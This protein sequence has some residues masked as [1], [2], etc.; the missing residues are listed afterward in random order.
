MKFFKIIFLIIASAS[1]LRSQIKV[2]PTVTHLAS[3]STPSAGAITL[4]VS[5][6]AA[7]Y[8]Y[9]WTP[10]S[11]TTQ[12]ISGKPYGS[13]TVKVTDSGTNTATFNY[14]IGYKVNWTECFATVQKHDT[15]VNDGSTN[16]GWGAAV[17]KN[18]LAGG[19]DGWFE[20]ILKDLNHYKK[21]GFLDSVSL[22]K[23][24]AT[25]I[26]YG[27]YYVVSQNRLCKIVN[28]AESTILNNPA[29]GTV[30]R[31]ERVGNVISLK[32]NGTVTYSTTSATD[33][34][35]IWK[36]KTS[37]NASDNGSFINVGCSFFSQGNI[38]FPGFGG[39]LPRVRHI[40]NPIANNGSITVNPSLNGNYTYSWQPGSV[41][42]SSITSLSLGSYSLTIQDSMGNKRKSVYSVGH[43]IRWGQFYGTAEKHD[44]LVNTGVYGWAHGISKN[45]IPGSTDGW[46][47]YVL[48]DLNQI[49]TIGFLD[50]IYSFGAIADVDYGFY[51][52]TDAKVL[53][54]V[55][56]GV[57]SPIENPLEGSILRVERV[58]STINLKV[59]GAVIYTTVNVTDV[60][61]KW[62]VKSHVLP[63]ATLIG[64]GMSTSACSLTAS[65]G[66][67]Q[68]ITCA[69][70]TVTLTGSSNTSGVTYSWSPGGSSPTSSITSVTSPGIYTLQVT[71]AANGCI[72]TSTTSVIQNICGGAVVA[73]YESDALGGSIDLNITGGKGPYNIAWNGVKLPSSV[74]A[75]NIITSLGYPLS[76]DSVIIK[77]GID[78][79]RQV[80]S[81]SGLGPGKHPVTIYDQLNDSINIIGV[82][83][84]EIDTAFTMGI[85]VIPTPSHTRRS[86]NISYFYGESV[87]IVQSGAFTSGQNFAVFANVI[88]RNENNV[89]EFTI[90]DTLKTEYVGLRDQ[91]P[92]IPNGTDDIKQRIC[93]EFLGS[94]YSV[95]V[96][97][98]KQYAGNYNPG[99]VFEMNIDPVTDFVYFSKNDAGVYKH[100]LSAVS[101]TDNL[102][103]KFVHGSA[104]GGIKD[105]SIKI[106]DAIKLRDYAINAIIGD[107]TCDL[108]CSGS[109][110]ATGQMFMYK[111]MPVQYELYSGA[112]SIPIA[113]VTD[114]SGGDHALFTNLCAG[115]Y[116]VK[117]CVTANVYYH[118]G[119]PPVSLTKPYCGSETFEIGYRPEWVNK[120]NVTSSFPGT[121]T[122]TSGNT[123]N[124]DAG[125]SSANYLA[126][127]SSG[128]I[129]WTTPSALSI[130]G[131]G[132][133]DADQ[134]QDIANIDY[135]VGYI[136]LAAPILGSNQLHFR[137]NNST[138]INAFLSGSP[139]GTYSGVRRFRLEKNGSNLVFKMNGAVINQT[140][141]S[142]TS[143]LILDASLK[144]LSG[145]INDLRMSFGCGARDWF[146]ELKKQYDAG[147]HF[148]QFKTLKFKYIEEYNQDDLDFKIFDFKRQLV[149]TNPSVVA[150]KEGDNRYSI[151][152]GSLVPSGIY[153][154]EVRNGKGELS[155]LKFKL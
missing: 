141:I 5:A 58:G 151:S 74:V 34:A 1:G 112:N 22:M 133:S 78:S 17:S 131:V 111:Y 121:L 137:T 49:K 31:V 53:A 132:F 89:I 130:N 68:T 86:G 122:K 26:D 136:K 88:K 129:E 41:A 14:S 83:G 146:A 85:V 69:N 119:D 84:S 147:C 10:G 11:Y 107:A 35:K 81:I 124:W 48:R 87:D 127:S 9:S 71:D 77:K 65:A 57:T 24:S 143:D 79:L 154:L 108:P 99:D 91:N 44:T 50:S 125:A 3:T 115:V 76:S 134:N 62:Y 42:S 150:K 23:T 98:L 116:T 37:L 95:W 67:S 153:Y 144:T 145:T 101:G 32:V 113:T 43:A 118:N 120:V 54:K 64:A 2:V 94:K 40:Y 72:M 135:G 90:P 117:Y 103:P 55:I 140:T 110:Y 97:N 36:V 19:Q 30:L 139:W 63:G 56:K 142:S 52:Y 73:N 149:V 16:I 66:A 100:A 82:I 38:V 106:G 92:M 51:Y 59:N 61:K 27:F 148:T 155:V 104:L 47:E 6:G 138:M 128:W 105:I 60:S 80:S 70:H 12:A 126:N 109:I 75:Y 28:G 13:Y 7:P 21:I 123:L 46:F 96:N 93:M 8:T 4:S 114:F 20:V 45:A 39:L 33:A 29:E 25:D 15:I 18:T 102:M 152:F